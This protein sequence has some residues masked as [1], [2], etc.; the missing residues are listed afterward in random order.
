MFKRLLGV[1]CLALLAALPA[2]GG[3]RLL[4]VDPAASTVRFTL[5]ATMHT[6]QGTFRVARGTVT[7]DAVPGPARGEIVVDAASGETGDRKRDAKMHAEVLL[8]ATHREIV[9][10]PRRLDGELPTAGRGTLKVEGVIRVLGM[11]HPV[12]LPLEVEVDGTTVRMSSA[13]QVPYVAWGLDDP[14][15]FLLRV[16]KEVAVQVEASG[17][18]SA[19]A[20]VTPASEESATP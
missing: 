5:G 13:F 2:A 3:E 17:T 8:S 15:V 18:L 20:G 14:S 7:F 19:A 6:V 10:E 9:L 16:A 4:T 1:S 12:T 11:E